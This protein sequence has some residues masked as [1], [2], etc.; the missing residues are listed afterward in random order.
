MLGVCLNESL[1]VVFWASH[2]YIMRAQIVVCWVMLEHYTVGKHDPYKKHMCRRD[3]LS[4]KQWSMLHKTCS[5]IVPLRFLKEK[6]IPKDHA[7]INLNLIPDPHNRHVRAQGLFTPWSMKLSQSF[8][9]WGRLP[10]QTIWLFAHTILLPNTTL[11]R[12][13]S[14]RHGRVREITSWSWRLQEN[15]PSF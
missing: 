8:I 5:G 4:T 1:C 2:C 6:S 15:Y 3:C 13:I 9:N 14:G 10:T 11:I 12:P 7:E